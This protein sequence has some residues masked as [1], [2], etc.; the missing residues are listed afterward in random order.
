MSDLKATRGEPCPEAVKE[1]SSLLFSGKTL[2]T[3][4]Q[5][6]GLQNQCF[7]VFLSPI[8]H[9]SLK[10]ICGT[11]RTTCGPEWQDLP[12]LSLHWFLTSHIPSYETEKWSVLS[13]QSDLVKHAFNITRDGK[14]ML[15]EAQQNTPQGRAQNWGCTL[16]SVSLNHIQGSVFTS[17]F[18]ATSFLLDPPLDS[19]P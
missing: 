15:T 1:T 19:I 17:T 12:L 5:I 14:R 2:Q 16:G 8:L 10:S 4:V 13:Q 6:E 11:K 3:I 7:N 18:P 9:M